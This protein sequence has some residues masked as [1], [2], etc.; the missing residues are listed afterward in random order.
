[1]ADQPAVFDLALAHTDLQLILAGIPQV[2]VVGVLE[3]VVVGTSRVFA[4]NEVA[5]IEGDPQPFDV[6]AQD[7]DGIGILG[8]VSHFGFDGDHH[9]FHGGDRH[10]FAKAFDFGVEGGSQFAGGDDDRHDL[11][12]F[13]Q[14]AD[15]GKLLV[16]LVPFS[17][18]LDVVRD[19][20][21]AEGAATDLLG[22]VEIGQDL[23][24]FQVPAPF[25]NRDFH[26][27]KF[28]IDQFRQGVLQR[29]I[30]KRGGRGGYVHEGGLQRDGRLR[31]AARGAGRCERTR[32]DGRG[33]PPPIAGQRKLNAPRVRKATAGDRAARRPNSHGRIAC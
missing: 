2:D 3:D 17:F 15:R 21:Q 20:C 13:G 11:I 19:G 18:D 12:R 16:V 29:Q 6:V 4:V 14:P 33:A 24:R 31:R 7:L 25:L 1:M 30:G 28:Q 26:A 23:G 32:G 22:L 5:G 27:G 8:H 10:Q 9:A